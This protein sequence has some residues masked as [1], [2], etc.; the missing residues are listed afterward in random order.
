M[1]RSPSCGE[2]IYMSAHHP[3]TRNGYLKGWGWLGLR[4]AIRLSAFCLTEF[5]R[6]FGKRPKIGLD[7]GSLYLRARN[8]YSEPVELRNGPKEVVILKA[9]GEHGTW[10]AHCPQ[11]LQ[12]DPRT[13]ASPFGQ[14]GEKQKDLPKEVFCVGIAGL[15]PAVSCSQSRRLTLGDILTVSALTTTRI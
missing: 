10:H 15:E 9:T 3:I 11:G 8:S 4:M 14:A 6:L 7:I 2:N 13:C 12:T 1:L 5:G